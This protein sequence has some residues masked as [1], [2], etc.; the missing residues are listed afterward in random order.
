[1]TRVMKYE[2]R[3][4]DPWGLRYSVLSRSYHGLS[5]IVCA[6]VFCY[7]GMAVETTD[8]NVALLTVM[9]LV[10]GWTAATDISWNIIPNREVMLATVVMLP[11]L[12]LNIER[13]ILA[14]FTSGFVFLVLFVLWAIGV[15]GVTRTIGAGDVKISPIVAFPLAMID[16]VW[17]LVWLV[18]TLCVSEIIRTSYVLTKTP[19]RTGM[20]PPM[21][22]AMLIAVVLVMT[23]ASAFNLNGVNYDLF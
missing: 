5:A 11:Y 8:A 10:C 22:P 4:G 3:I 23:T 12:I 16:P 14:L 21:L 1:M 6:V 20:V 9:G 2:P 19:H 13:G 7:A 18:I 17:S 15:R